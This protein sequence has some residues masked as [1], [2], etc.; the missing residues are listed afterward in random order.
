MCLIRW[1][2]RIIAL[3]KDIS[4]NNVNYDNIKPLSL[5]NFAGPGTYNIAIQNTLLLTFPISTHDETFFWYTGRMQFSGELKRMKIHAH[6]TL[7]Q[8]AIFFAASPNDLGMI[9]D[10]GFLLNIPPYIAMKPLEVGFQTNQELK[11][12]LLNNL[13]KSQS[14]YNEKHNNQDNCGYPNPAC[15][16]NKPIVICQSY[17]SLEVINHI[18]YDRKEPTCCIPWE[19]E[20]GQV[21]TVIGFN[22]HQG[23]PLGLYSPDIKN[24]PDTLPG[25]IGWWLYYHSIDH[26]KNNTTD[27][28]ITST[29]SHY[30]YSIYNH[31]ENGGM[32]NISSIAGYQKIAMLINGY[33]S[34][35]FNNWIYTPNAI[36]ASIVYGIVMNLTLS[37]IILISIIIIIFIIYQKKKRISIFKYCKDRIIYYYNY[38]KEVDNTTKHNNIMELNDL[39]E[40]H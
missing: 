29:I 35:N 28:T 30:G 13:L 25:H 18:A 31:L 36:I 9:E 40:Y 17:G 23:Y 20:S 12:F 38:S 26:L 22:K 7:F 6:N 33:T 5:H 11:E 19:W 10:N 3:D 8:E 37:I 14:L 15:H 16:I 2:P 32:S 24:I 21:F 4:S 1:V 27:N 39:E 34:P